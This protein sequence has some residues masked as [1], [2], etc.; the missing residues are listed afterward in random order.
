MRTPYK[1]YKE[2]HT[3]DD[4]KNI[5]SFKALESTVVMYETICSVL[6]LNKKHERVNP[7]CELQLGKRGLYENIGAWTKRDD[8]IMDLL[9]FLAHI[10]GNTDL[11]EIAER[12][13]KSVLLFSD[14][15]NVC[16]DKKLLK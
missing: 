15:V 1:E 10:D 7:Y 3:S 11:I 12:K 9:H 13:N 2:Y 14:I 4:N 8:F 5:M 6:E 16:K